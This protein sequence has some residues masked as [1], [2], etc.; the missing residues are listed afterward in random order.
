MPLFL[1]A[2]LMLGGLFICMSVP[3]IQRK[4]APNGWYGFRVRRTLEDPDIQTLEEY[5]GELKG[6]QIPMDTVWAVLGRLN[7]KD[8]PQDVN[9]KVGIWMK[10]RFGE[11]YR[12][13]IDGKR[14][15]V[16]GDS[17]GPVMRPRFR[18]NTI[19]VEAIYE[20][21]NEF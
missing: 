21:T 3:L 5:F 14:P 10:E 17:G 11:K 13:R 9:A 15:F 12:A 19:Q 6:V 20:L 16:Y 18:D 1:T 4:V 2:F 7:P 8:R